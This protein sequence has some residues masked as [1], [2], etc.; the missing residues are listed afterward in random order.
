M[1]L[2]QSLFAMETHKNNNFTVTAS[3]ERRCGWELIH[4]IMGLHGAHGCNQCCVSEIAYVNHLPTISSPTEGLVSPI[5]QTHFM[6]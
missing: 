5:T 6:L 3:K 2:I 4:C 1:V